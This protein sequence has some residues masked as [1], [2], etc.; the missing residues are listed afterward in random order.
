M[1]WECFRDLGRTIMLVQEMSEA[2]IVMNKLSFALVD[3]IEQEY[4]N[5]G[6]SDVEH[7]WPQ[8][9]QLVNRFPENVRQ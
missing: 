3:R 5:S 7:L 8:L 6:G 1:D 9:M 2:G 4:K